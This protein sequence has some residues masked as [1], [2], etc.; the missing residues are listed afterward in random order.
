MLGRPSFCTSQVIGREFVSKMTHNVLS[1]TL[2]ICFTPCHFVICCAMIP[3]GV[4]GRG[5]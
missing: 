2:L 5:C 3:G 1:M 4:G